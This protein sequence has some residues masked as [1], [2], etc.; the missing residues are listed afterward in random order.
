MQ[1][2]SSK[3]VQKQACLTLLNAEIGEISAIHSSQKRVNQNTD[4]V[5]DCG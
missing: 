5:P 3:A 2:R 1:L 4:D